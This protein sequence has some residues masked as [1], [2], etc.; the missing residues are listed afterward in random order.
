VTPEV[1][2]GHDERSRAHNAA[3]GERITNDIPS[4]PCLQNNSLSPATNRASCI[5]RNNGVAL[6]VGT[7]DLQPCHTAPNVTCPSDGQFV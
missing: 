2:L 1:G 7:I 6:V 3:F 4:N 5:A